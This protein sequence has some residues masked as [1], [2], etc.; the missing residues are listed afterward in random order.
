MNKLTEQINYYL[1]YCQYQKKLNEKTIKAYRIDLTQFAAFGKATSD[2]LTKACISQ[3]IQALHQ[4]Y[5]PKT[6]KRK[7]ACI[8]AF[9]NYMEF[10]E[11]IETNPISK[12]RIE[13]REPTT[14]PKSLPLK[15]IGKLL[16]TAHRSLGKKQSTFQQNTGLRNIAVLELLFATG[17]RVSEL[18]SIGSKDID[19]KNG[20]V[21]VWGKGAKE[22]IIFISNQET[23]SALRQYR[24]T[25]AH[26]I[27]NTGCF[28]INRLGHK[29]NEQSVRDII[30]SYAKLAKIAE[31]ITPHMI[32]HSFATLM[33][34]EDVDIRYIQSILGHS[35][36]STT[37]IYTHV[38]L[39]KQR[40]IMRKKHPRNRIST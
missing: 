32:R 24:S 30:R 7:I 33:L 15:T 12:I 36:I 27:E 22:R 37:Q 10:D 20:F 18:C 11:Q 31:H 16:Q 9:I 2:P 8:R 26:Q 4:K 19:L 1:D 35:S 28:F 6:A 13:F 29:L 3:Y 38:S 40:N 21:K 14:L 5:K 23:L 39:G 25:F 34:E 17:L